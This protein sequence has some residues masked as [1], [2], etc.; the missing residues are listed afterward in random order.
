M[1]K[2]T[3]RLLFNEEP[4]TINRLGA[5]VL[6]LNEA[7]VVQQ[8]HYWLEINRKA[9]KNFYENRYWTYNTY[10]QWTTEN[11][12]FWSKRTVQRIFKKLFDSKI[13][14]KGN[15]NKKGYD[16][17]V[18]V[19]IDYDKLDE[20]LS[21]F[22]YNIEISTECQSVTMS[23]SNR[24]TN[25][26]G[27]MTDCHGGVTDCHSHDD[28][29]SLPIP[30]TTTKTTT[31]ISITTQ[32]VDKPLV[33][34]NENVK[35]IEDNTHLLLD[36]KNKQNKVSAWNK[37]RL[38]KAIEIFKE[39]QGEYFSLL[40]KIYKNDKNFVIK[41][42]DSSSVQKVKTRF[43]NIS[44]RYANYEPDE[45][46][47]L[48]KEGQKDKFTNTNNESSIDMNA[49][50]ERAIDLLQEKINTD[51]TKLF[52]QNVRLNLNAFENEINEICNELLSK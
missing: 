33:V 16:Q 8:I 30:K 25:C 43:H 2:N 3:S 52:K 24:V 39:Q 36:S 13:L 35:L 15:F 11:F 10:E 45:L 4:I 41:S 5:R 38:L 46:E 19:T 23:N 26:H 6:G 18:W 1:I 49:I 37:D 22:E 32:S 14:L 12:N 50:R 44:Q 29:L 51:N 9:Q 20:I 17:T 27:G 48:L 34:I 7:I 28:N 31:E 40:E 21:E 42:S 47:K